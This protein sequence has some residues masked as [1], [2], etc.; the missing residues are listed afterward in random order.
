M[1]EML[2][3]SEMSEITL[4]LNGKVITLPLSK[5]TSQYIKG[6]LPFMRVFNFPDRYQEATSNYHCFLSGNMKEIKDPEYLF[7]CFDLESYLDDKEYFNYLIQQMFDHWSSCQGMITDHSDNDILQEVLLLCPYQL[8]PQYMRNN[9]NFIKLWLPY[10]INRKTKVNQCEFYDSYIKKYQDGNI[11]ELFY[12]YDNGDN[13]AVQCDYF[14]LYFDKSKDLIGVGEYIHSGLKNGMNQ[15]YYVD[16]F[17]REKD[18][19]QVRYFVKNFLLC[20]TSTTWFQNGTMMS[21]VEY[22][23]DKKCGYDRLWGGD[24]KFIHEISY[25]DDILHGPYKRWDNHHF[26]NNYTLTDSGEYVNGKKDGLWLEFTS[27]PNIPLSGF[28]EEGEYHN[29]E[30]IGIWKELVTVD[31]DDDDYDNRVC[32]GPYQNG[33]RHGVWEVYDRDYKEIVMRY[34]Y[35]NGEL[36]KM[37]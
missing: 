29:G 18:N 24:G 10:H 3:M 23:E 33:K 19:V 28:I 9:P 27:S 16:L 1:L 22:N 4:T 13:K 8:L 17:D 26:T 6:S 5:I 25:Q 15:I 32:R 34:H 31:I 30:K 37:I 20:G 35:E 12:Y 11:K 7:S 2:E 21:E 14:K 36:I